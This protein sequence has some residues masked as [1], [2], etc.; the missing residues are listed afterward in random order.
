MVILQIHFDYTGAFGDEMVNQTSEL[1]HSINDEPGFIWKIWTEH[2]EKGIAG[3]IYL[4][5][6]REHASAYAKKHMARLT[7]FGMGSNFVYEIMDVNEPLSQINQAK[8]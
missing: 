3:G 7:D 5:D 1:A 8:L 6:S 4:F 2:A